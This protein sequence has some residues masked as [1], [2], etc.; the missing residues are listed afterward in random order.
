ME[1]GS[2]SVAVILPKGVKAA[3][4]AD[5]S[6]RS[7]EVPTEDGFLSCCRR[8]FG[9]AR[10]RW[11]ERVSPPFAI[12]GET[13]GTFE[14]ALDWVATILWSAR[15]EETVVAV[16]I[17]AGRKTDLYSTAVSAL[18]L[19]EIAACPW[20]V[21]NEKAARRGAL[22]VFGRKIDLW[23]KAVSALEL[24]EI[25]ACSWIVRSERA[26][27][28]GAPI[29]AEQKFDLWSTVVSALEL[30]VTAACP[31]T[32]RS[33]RAARHGAPIVALVLPSR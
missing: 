11:D 16:E 26:A 10:F 30:D 24:D 3:P 32:V 6:G 33:E 23:S 12:G 31:W 25:A 4:R 28:R 27:R 2:S 5:S 19:D 29:V 1:A 15:Y 8:S 7:L 17:A 21:R 9:L 20:T 13:S 14:I 22:I 18:E